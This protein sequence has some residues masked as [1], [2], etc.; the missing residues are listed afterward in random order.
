MN[1]IFFSRLTRALLWTGVCAAF[2]LLQHKQLDADA[3][4]AIIVS[5]GLIAMTKLGLLL[6]FRGEPINMGDRLTTLGGLLASQYD[7]KD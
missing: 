4:L 3:M 1:S 2:L 6:V 7:R 5:V